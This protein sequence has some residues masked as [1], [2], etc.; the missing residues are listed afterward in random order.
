MY[1]VSSE[2]QLIPHRVHAFIRVEVHFFLLQ[3][4]NPCRKISYQLLLK[5]RE[6]VKSISQ[7]NYTKKNNYFFHTANELNH[8]FLLNNPLNTSANSSKLS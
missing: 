7:Q 4:S 8:L 6:L 2:P 3:L 1:L 5:R